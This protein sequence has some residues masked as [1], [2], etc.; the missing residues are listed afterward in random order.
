MYD[1]IE[2]AALLNGIALGQVGDEPFYLPLPWPF[3]PDDPG[4][5]P[6]DPDDPEPTPGVTPGPVPVRPANWDLSTEPYATYTVASGDTFT[7]LAATYLLDGARWTEIWNVQPQAFRWG[8]SPDVLWPGDVLNMPAEAK[9]NFLKL[10]KGQL[11]HPGGDVPVLPGDEKGSKSR[12]PWIAAGVA[13]LA[14]GAYYLT[15]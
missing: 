14:G 9:Q 7:G 2:A 4:P 5:P 1:D 3:D 11:P 8:R 6:D 10:K 15:R 12:M 13:A